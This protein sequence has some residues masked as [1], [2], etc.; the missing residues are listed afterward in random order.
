M[1]S[2]TG[3]SAQLLTLHGCGYEEKKNF[4]LPSGYYVMIKATSVRRISEA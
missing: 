1:S 2:T 4:F 3:K